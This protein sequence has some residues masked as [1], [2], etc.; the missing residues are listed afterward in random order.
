MKSV[1]VDAVY[2]I[3]IARPRDPWRASAE[4]AG[5]QLGEVQFV[6]SDEV[7]TELL[8]AFSRGGPR[9]RLAAARLVRNLMTESTVHIVPQNRESF[10]AAL[11][12]YEAR[13]DKGY[14]LQD[15]ASMNVMEAKGID[16]ILTNDRHFE[17][18]GFTVLMK[19]NP[20]G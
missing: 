1:F 14:S 2:W 15:C 10:R 19:R 7:L 5:R 17:Q 12:R 16:S 9:I 6:T 3:A 8:T 13:L 18:E 20:V 11:K 4:E